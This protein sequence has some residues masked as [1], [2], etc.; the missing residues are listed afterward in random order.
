MQALVHSLPTIAALCSAIAAIAAVIVTWRAPRSAAKYA[1]ELRLVSSKVEEGR[2]LK[3]H[4]FRELL[5]ARGVQITRES[6]AAM[7][8]IDLA[9]CK[10]PMVRDAWSELY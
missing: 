7:N 6:V 8:L 3:F 9:F 4:I 10:S 5:K 1:E 2:R